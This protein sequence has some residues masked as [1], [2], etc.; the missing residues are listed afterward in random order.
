M[1]LDLFIS[2]AEKRGFEVDSSDFEEDGSLI[3]RKANIVISRYREDENSEFEIKVQFDGKTLNGYDLVAYI[4]ELQSANL[5]A[6]VM[7]NV[8]A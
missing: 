7:E 1:K 3:V 4:E 5:L 6:F 2:D 8:E